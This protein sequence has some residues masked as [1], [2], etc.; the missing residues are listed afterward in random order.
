MTISKAI[1]G[2]PYQPNNR[3]TT[4][5]V[6]NVNGTPDLSTDIHG[7]PYNQTVVNPRVNEDLSPGPSGYIT[8]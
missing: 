1:S 6:T 2:N 7:G 5:P 8:V 3:A 4:G